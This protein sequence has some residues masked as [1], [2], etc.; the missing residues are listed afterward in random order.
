MP[1]SLVTL[2][3]KSTILLSIY[4]TDT[5]STCVTINHIPYSNSRCC[6]QKSS[7]CY[8]NTSSF[9]PFSVFNKY[10]CLMP[11][12]IFP[13]SNTSGS[14]HTVLY[15]SS[16]FI[17]QFYQGVT[18]AYPFVTPLSLVVTRSLM[19]VVTQIPLVVTRASTVC[20]LLKYHLLLTELICLLLK[21]HCLIQ[22][23]LCLLLRYHR[24]LPELNYLLLK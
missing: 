17:T 8:S 20:L 18:R 15:C 11:K 1:K 4:S 23:F 21:F 22:V 5:C 6:Y 2:P 3:L 13:Y 24:L 12:L 19:C 9:Y 10:L 14:K 7:A 16:F